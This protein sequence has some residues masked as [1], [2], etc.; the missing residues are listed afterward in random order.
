MGKHIKFEKGCCLHI[1]QLQVVQSK[2]KRE[3]REPNSLWMKNVKCLN[4]E[5]E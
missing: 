3:R 5:V 1:W 4:Y 2:K